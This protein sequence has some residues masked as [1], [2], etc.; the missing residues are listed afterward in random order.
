VNTVVVAGVGMTPFR[1]SPGLGLRAMA[2]TAIAEALAD[3]DVDGRDIE[4]V[5]FGN[6]A[7]AT[8]TQQ[9]M[10][11]GQVALRHGVLDGASVI[12]VENACAS[13]SSAFNLA[14]GLI[15]GGQ[16]DVVLAIGAEQL[17]HHLKELSFRALRGAADIVEIGEA[18]PDED[19]TQSVLMRFYAEEARGFMER[20]DVTVE[21][22]ARVAVKNR[23]H[24]T[25]NPRAQYRTEQTMEQVLTGRLIAEPL[26][27]PMC[28][29]M[30]DGAAAVILMSEEEAL[31]RGLE[32][33]VRVRASEVSGAAAGH[34]VEHAARAAYERAGFGVADVHL[35]ELHDAA[36]TAEVIQ[37]GEIGLVPYGEE[38]R[39]LRSGAT[40]LGG[41][42]P[43]NV[44]G[45]LLS[46]GH[47]IG[48]TGLAQ[49]YELVTQLRGRAGER[50]VEGAA[51]ALA[52]NTGGWVAGDYAVAVASVLEAV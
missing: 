35:I 42:I 44:S 48:A 17:T 28:S 5:L 52:V 46:R 49:I 36:A 14:F 37:Y 24:A 2:D 38:T 26:T 20:S 18:G 27:L 19:W 22:F 47:A 9:D 31:R 11:K 25:M 39:I 16:N 50:Q 6:A 33:Y 43:V 13:G 12:N 40:A 15:A 21:D 3:A 30:T 29:P 1:R 45:G 8:V 32:E 41:E 4:R 23:H 7:S 10:V 34:P 51:R